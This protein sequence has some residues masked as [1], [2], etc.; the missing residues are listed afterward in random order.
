MS[1][2]RIVQ[3]L[4]PAR[5]CIVGAAYEAASEADAAQTQMLA[6]LI[7]SGAIKAWCGICGSRELHFEDAATR[8]ATMAEAQP[9]VD[10]LQDENV[11]TRIVLSGLF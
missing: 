5:H 1:C 8:F 3:L 7:H 2:V 6:G 10:R 11:I 9:H 4:C